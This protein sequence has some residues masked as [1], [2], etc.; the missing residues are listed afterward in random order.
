[1]MNGPPVSA[2]GADFQVVVNAKSAIGET[3]AR[4]PRQLCRS[5][6]G[7]E[8]MSIHRSCVVAVN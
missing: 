6:R 3:D 8:R 7:A 4:L 1:M 2:A 5:S